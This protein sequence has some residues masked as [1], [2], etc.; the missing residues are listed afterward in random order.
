M[1]PFRRP[2]VRP[3]FPE[4][5]EMKATVKRLRPELWAEAMQVGTIAGG[6][7]YLAAAVGVEPLPDRFSVLCRQITDAVTARAVAAEA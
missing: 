4:F 6:M 7:A 3:C 1:W 5:A 2:Q